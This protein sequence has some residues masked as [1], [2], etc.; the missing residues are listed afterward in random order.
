MQILFAV[1]LNIGPVVVVAVVLLGVLDGD[2]EDGVP[3]FRREAAKFG[4]G[5]SASE[6]NNSSLDMGMPPISSCRSVPA[7]GSRYQLH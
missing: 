7:E 3:L 1:R 5:P 4:R 2:R 6:G